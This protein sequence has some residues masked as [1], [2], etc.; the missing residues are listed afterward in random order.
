MCASLRL[1]FACVL[2]TG[3]APVCP[4][5][6][7]C[8]LLAAWVSPSQPAC[9]HLPP[10][11]VLTFNMFI[12]QRVCLS[13]CTHLS[14][15]V[16]VPRCVCVLGRGMVRGRLCVWWGWQ[17]FKLNLM[18]V[19]LLRWRLHHFLLSASQ[20]LVLGRKSCCLGGFSEVK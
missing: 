16:C 11:E 10:C 3:F 7:A 20:T 5:M 18:T 6:S 19:L 2:H 1:V 9:Q 17:C 8:A 13:A 12:S 4:S 15:C 14:Q